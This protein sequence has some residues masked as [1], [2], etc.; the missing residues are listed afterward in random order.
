M[1]QPANQYD[2]DDKGDAAQKPA[3][4]LLAAFSW[5]ISNSEASLIDGRPLGR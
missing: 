4:F 3:E 1:T 5:L 2:D